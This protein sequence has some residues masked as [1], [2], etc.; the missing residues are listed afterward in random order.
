[1]RNVGYRSFAMKFLLL[2]GLAVLSTGNISTLTTVAQ[3]NTETPEATPNPIPSLPLMQG[4]PLVQATGKLLGQQR[5]Q[6][7]SEI[8]ITGKVPNTPLISHAQISTTVAAP[9]KVKAEI[10]F[11]DANGLSD[12][13]YQV[14]SDGIQVWIYD[15]KQNQYSV[16][17]YQQF[18]E[19]QAGLAVGTVSNFYLK[20]LNGVRNNKIASRALT[21]LPPDRLLRYFQ[22]FANIDLLN[23]IIRNEQIEGQTYAV[24]D[25]N[26]ADRSFKVITYVDSQL[27]NIERVDLSGTKDGLDM[28]VKEEIINQAIPATIPGD[29]FNFSPPKDV[30]QLTEQIAIEP[31]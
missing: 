27:A 17:E 15:L 19:S 20:T 9:N 24:Y 5:Y 1:M 8:E 7:E 16:S 13:Q 14:I 4:V 28:V 18:I 12:R 11:V 25:L 22:R 10:T 31:F 21:K 26:A 29:T 6:I 30:E 3:T 2:I 23:M